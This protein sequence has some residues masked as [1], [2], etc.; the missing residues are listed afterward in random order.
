MDRIHSVSN[1]DSHKWQRIKHSFL[2]LIKA[3][4]LTVQVQDGTFAVA[5]TAQGK[6]EG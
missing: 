2:P 4:G 1:K 6:D 5:V 3:P